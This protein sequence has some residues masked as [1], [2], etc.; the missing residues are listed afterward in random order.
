MVEKGDRL[1]ENFWGDR[2][3][4]AEYEAL[5]DQFKDDHQLEK[6]QTNLAKYWNL[7]D[8]SQVS[9][10]MYKK[11][12]G[13]IKPQIELAEVKAEKSRVD[14]LTNTFYR[15]AAILVL[16]LLLSS[17]YFFGAW[18]E[19]SGSETAYAEIYCPPGVR[20]RFLLPD[21]TTGWLNGDSYLTY[22]VH[23]LQNR[24]VELKGE[25]YFDVR[26]DKRS[27]FLVNAGG[28]DVEVLG[29]QFNVMA[30]DDFHRVEVTLD[31]GAVQVRKEGTSLNEVLVP[32]EHLVMDTREN[33]VSVKTVQTHYFTSWKDGFLEFR[34]VPLHEVAAR[35]GRWYNTDIIIQDEALKQIPYRATFKDESLERVLALLAL[36]APINYE[37]IEPKKNTDEI[38]EKRKVILSYKN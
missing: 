37:I 24:S 29:T 21:G 18:W 35:L 20:S 5:V 32:K 10:E 4:K 6:L 12:W 23:F 30:Y 7:A 26:E 3:S 14:R 34:N 16:P 9:D 36:S 28:L 22:P 13:R 1:L 2:Y 38:Y 11:L 19:L 8:G 27:P 25:A 17:L 31:E 15:I 33:Q